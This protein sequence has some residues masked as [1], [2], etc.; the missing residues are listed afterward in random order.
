MSAGDVSFAT[1]ALS[2]GMLTT[3]LVL[4]YWSMR[5]QALARRRFPGTITR[6]PNWLSTPIRWETGHGIPD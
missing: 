1:F 3:A 4:R 5:K 2:V 6:A